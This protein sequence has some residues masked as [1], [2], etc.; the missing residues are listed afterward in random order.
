MLLLK[1]TAGA[2]VS[3]F[4]LVPHPSSRGAMWR[5]PTDT[6]TCPGLHYRRGTLSLGNQNHFQWGVSLFTFAL[7]RDITLITLYRNLPFA[8]KGSTISLFQGS[9]LCQHPWKES[10][11]QRELVFYPARPGEIG[12][13]HEEAF[14]HPGFLPGGSLQTSTEKGQPQQS[15][16]VSFSWNVRG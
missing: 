4:A 16:K 11:K 12:E 14:H 13:T 8:L 10:K 3:A 9:S 6:C 2:R 7:Q 1:A 15:L 5:G